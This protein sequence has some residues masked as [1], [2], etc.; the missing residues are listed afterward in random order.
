[1]LLNQHITAG[2]ASIERQIVFIATPVR[3]N[4]SCCVHLST[5]LPQVVS[6]PLSV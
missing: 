2:M 5:L 4:K 6:Y 1:M 3:E